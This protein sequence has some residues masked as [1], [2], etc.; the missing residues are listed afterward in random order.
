MYW[1]VSLHASLNQQLLL[2]KPSTLAYLE[3]AVVDRPCK[4]IISTCCFVWFSIKRN[5]QNVYVHVASSI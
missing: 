1:W 3:P 4:L 2:S 5:S